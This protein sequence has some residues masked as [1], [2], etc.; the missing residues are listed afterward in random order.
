[1]RN[2]CGQCFAK[3]GQT[4]SC[5]NGQCQPC[6]SATTDCDGDGWTAAEG[7]CCDQPGVCGAHPEL[8]NPGAFDFPGN[9]I[10]EN[11]NG[12]TDAAD[13]LDNSACDQTLASNS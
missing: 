6:N 4:D 2:N 10:D 12:L 11:C 9:G 1:D 8:I 5:V 3:C 7:D 13:T